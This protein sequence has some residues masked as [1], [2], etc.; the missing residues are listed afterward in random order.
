MYWRLNNSSQSAPS[1]AH[2][3]PVFHLRRAEM[4][5]KMIV[6]FCLLITVVEPNVT[7]ATPGVDLSLHHAGL[8]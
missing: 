3:H 8:L 1:N 6:D 4:G 7:M 2:S 5:A